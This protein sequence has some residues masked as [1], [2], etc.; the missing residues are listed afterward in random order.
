MEFERYNYDNIKNRYMEYKFHIIETNKYIQYYLNEIK[1][2]NNKI[3]N[4]M[5]YRDNLIKNNVLIKIINR[6]DD[7]LKYAFL[8]WRK[9]SSKTKRQDETLLKLLRRN[10]TNDKNLL[11]KSFINWRIKAIKMKEKNTNIKFLLSKMLTRKDYYDNQQSLHKCFT[12]WRAK[13]IKMKEENSNIIFLLSKI[14]TRKYYYDNQQ[15]L[16]KYF[17]NWR[18]KAIK[19]KEE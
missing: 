16:H 14:L 7:S 2:I 3:I 9:N 19:M 4:L 8:K 5:L 12:N 13:A 1:K 6:Q 15:S 17:T 11:L 18:V 10:I